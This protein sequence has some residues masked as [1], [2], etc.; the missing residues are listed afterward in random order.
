MSEITD[1]PPSNA[2]DIIA[3]TRQA[4]ALQNVDA[5][6]LDY[7][8]VD[9]SGRASI[10]NLEM[11]REWPD[12]RRGTAHPSDVAS[13]IGYVETYSSDDD[14][15]IWVHPT[16]GKIVAIIDDHSKEHAA[17]RE[18]KAQLDLKHSQ[19]WIFWTRQDGNL[20]DQK[21]FAEHL[22]EG[23]PDIAQP[24]G[25]TLLE[26]ATTFEA[27]TNVQFRSGVDISSGETKFK[28]DESIEAT[29]KTA[30][31]EVAV[32]REF[33]LVLT[34]FLGEE[35]VQITASLRHDTRGGNLRLGYKLERPERAV[36]DALQRVADRLD[37]R[38]ARVYRGTPA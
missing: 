37:D 32:P 23:L 8:V 30:D 21:S 13:F 1:A 6:A 9:V 29:G 17:W 10:L 4:A 15:T 31:G 22:R 18:H 34:P 33:V 26:I 16:E 14:T 36:E 25:A 20:V 7:A 12:R 35:S 27:K 2:A 24:D 11:L 28:Y 38:F 5:D 19:E 3:V